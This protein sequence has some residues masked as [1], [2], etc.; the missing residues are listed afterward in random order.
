[1][2]W[3][4]IYFNIVKIKDFIFLFELFLNSFWS[5]VF[6]FY[7]I[8]IIGVCKIVVLNLYWRRNEL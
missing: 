2:E 6:I 5:L 7:I 3:E 4:D 8:V 1:M